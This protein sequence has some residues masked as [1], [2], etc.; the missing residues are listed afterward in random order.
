[1]VWHGGQCFSPATGR[2]QIDGETFEGFALDGTSPR[3]LPRLVC[4]LRR[5]GW[6]H[7]RSGGLRLAGKPAGTARSQWTDVKLTGWPYPAA[8]Y[9]ANLKQS[10]STACSTR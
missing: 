3:R 7:G 1:M 4:G 6:D 10:T 2:L 9:G 5:R 8:L